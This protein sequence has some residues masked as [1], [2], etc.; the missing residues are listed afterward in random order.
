MN[1][2]DQQAFKG[3]GF[4][5]MLRA[6]T[7]L[8]GEAGL[9]KVLDNASPDLKTLTTRKVLDNEWIQDR[10][11]TELMVSADRILGQGDLS[12]IRKIS[13]LVAK[14]NLTGIYKIYVKMTSINGLLKRA[15]QIWKQY[16]NSGSVKTLLTEPNHFQ[17]EVLD[18]HPYP[19]TC[20]G[21]L[22]WLDMFM[23]VYKR[24]GVASHPECKRSGHSRCI[25]DIKLE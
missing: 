11:G 19:D 1:A 12:Q 22:G 23:E 4:K 6:I 25:F 8:H 9:K 5:A 20:I 7:T 17:F 14:D 2:Q 15:D 13:Y 10:L 18:H 3:A 21:V 24:K 16:F